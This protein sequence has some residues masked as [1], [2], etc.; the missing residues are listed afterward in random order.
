MTNKHVKRGTSYV[1]R[2]TQI[3]TTQYISITL[4][5]SRGRRGAGEEKNGP[6]PEQCLYQM[7]VRMCS[8]RISHLL[9]VA[10]TN[11][12][13]TLEDSLAVSFNWQFLSN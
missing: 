13:A 8:K 7:L 1:I 12:T 4:A 9:W 10:M 11:S 2:E 5:Q 6:N 3:K